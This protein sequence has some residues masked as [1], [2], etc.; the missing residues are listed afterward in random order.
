M[1]NIPGLNSNYI[2]CIT[3]DDN[4]YVILGTNN[5]LLAFT[6]SQFIK[7]PMFDTK[8]RQF[9]TYV[10]QVYTLRNKDIAVATSGYG[11]LIK[12]LDA[13]ECHTLKGDVE[14]LKYIRKLL[15]DKQGRLWIITENGKLYRKETNGKLTSYFGG[16]EGLTAQDIQQDSFGNFYLA[17][18]NQG[19]YEL[20][21]AATSLLKYP[22]LAICLYIVSI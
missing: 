7:I 9:T 8:G 10:N 12:K 14:K 20:K 11:I 18:K 5:S 21:K 4:G 19:I 15:E 6:G 2:N 22:T 17:S 16:T 3:Q 1:T 13:Q